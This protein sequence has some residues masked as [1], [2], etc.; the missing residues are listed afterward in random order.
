MM[1]EKLCLV[2]LLSMLSFSLWAQPNFRERMKERRQEIEQVKKEFITQRIN[3]KAEQEKDFWTVYDNYIE[4]KIN[5]KRQ[6][7]AL[8]NQSDNLTST[9]K[10]LEESLDK[11]FDLQQ[12]ELDLDRKT[13]TEL[14]KIINIRQLTELYKS[15]NEFIR[16]LVLTLREGRM[17]NRE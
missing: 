17:G 6:I 11:L 2:I 5:I 13:K 7:A 12:T 1:K 10:E 9:D 3:L 16:K 14:L 8:K 4:Q 15:E